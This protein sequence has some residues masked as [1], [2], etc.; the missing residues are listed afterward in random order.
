MALRG[1]IAQLAGLLLLCPSRRS[2]TQGGIAVSLGVL[3]AEC[4]AAAEGIA[5]AKAR[6]GGNS[7]SQQCLGKAARLVAQAIGG[8]EQ[9]VRPFHHGDEASEGR[10]MAIRLL[11]EARR[12]MGLIADERAGLVMVGL[13]HGCCCHSG[14][15]ARRFAE[16][17]LK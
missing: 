1:M 4:S 16:P 12:L 5:A 2:E 15:A 14:Q 10:A 13:S 3:R 7:L 17:A 6:L 8:L 9:A 11:E